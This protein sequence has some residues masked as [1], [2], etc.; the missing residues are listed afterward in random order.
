M[1]THKNNFA[2]FQ[3]IKTFFQSF[4]KKPIFVLKKIVSLQVNYKSSV[5]LCNSCLWNL[6][7]FKR[8]NRNKYKCRRNAGLLTCYIGYFL[9]P[10]RRKVDSLLKNKV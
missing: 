4:F 2:D 6:R 10:Q 7:N 1:K 5:L 3:S 9:E 8:N